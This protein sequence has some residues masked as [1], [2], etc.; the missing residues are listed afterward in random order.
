VKLGVGI[1]AAGAATQAIHLPT[2]ARLPDHFQ[3]VAVTDVDQALAAA[4]ARAASAKA[5]S[6]L[7]EMLNDPAVDVVAICSPDRFHADQIAM[8][9]GAS[10]CGLLCEKPLATSLSEAERIVESV[11]A[12]GIPLVVGTMHAYDPVWLE[13]R[14]LVAPLLSTTTLI[15]STLTL[16]L[17]PTLEDQASEILGR[18]LSAASSR[19]DQARD[20]I[21]FAE[22]AAA[23][24]GLVLGLWIHDLPWIRRM[25][26]QTPRVDAVMPL[27]PFGATMA[28]T[29]GHAQIQLLACMRNVWEPDWRLDAWG[30]GW[31]LRIEVPPSYVHVGA[32]KVT[33]WDKTG[34]RVFRGGALDGYETE[35]L[36]LHRLVTDGRRPRYP[37]EELQADLRYA[38]A[39]A[40]GAVDRLREPDNSR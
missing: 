26:P 36:E 39:I 24:R 19:D 23:L 31:R 32:A 10:V 18:P 1:V 3:V 33:L 6:S 34:E 14:Q 11:A 22:R 25:A 37:L 20:E 13:V 12:A 29:A 40:D 38:L 35:W 8:A 16:P 28:L 17:N 7:A 27:E 30:D 2:L 5:A 21:G 4:V 15:R 9:C